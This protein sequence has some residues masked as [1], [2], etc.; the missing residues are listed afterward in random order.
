MSY[1][2]GDKGGVA[3]R[4]RGLAGVA[5]GVIAG[6]MAGGAE[7]L[8]AAC[9]YSGGW[10]DTLSVHSFLSRRLLPTCGQ[11]TASQRKGEAVS[12][13]QR[14]RFWCARM[15]KVPAGNQWLG[16]GPVPLSASVGWTRV[17]LLSGAQCPLGSGPALPL[18]VS[19]L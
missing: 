3:G 17:R 6:R 14:L 11:E 10:S 16:D 2:N 8:V 18:T 7:G 13:A 15:G 9:P 4:G 5:A 1:H 12:R 19:E